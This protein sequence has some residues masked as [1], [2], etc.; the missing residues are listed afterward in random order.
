MSRSHAGDV[1]ELIAA[2]SEAAIVVV[3]TQRQLEL[4]LAHA[5]QLPL[6]KA[7]VMYLPPLPPILRLPRPRHLAR[8]HTIGSTGV[9]STAQDRSQIRREAYGGGKQQRSDTGRDVGRDAHV[10]ER[11]DG[12]GCALARLVSRQRSL[13]YTVRLSGT[14]ALHRLTVAVA[15]AVALDAQRCSG[16]DVHRLSLRKS[17]QRC[18]CGSA[19]P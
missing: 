12:S 6:L 16:A 10:R 9:R 18:Q 5:A 8:T 11:C 14:V 4:Y 7:I 19:Q 2:H 1:C 3:E 15:V 17:A 13:Q